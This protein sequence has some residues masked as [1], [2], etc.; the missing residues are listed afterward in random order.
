MRLGN[1]RSPETIVR[2]MSMRT[3]YN[4]GWVILLMFMVV[5][6]M[7]ACFLK[8]PGT[9]GNQLPQHISLR[10]G[11]L[12]S[13]LSPDN[14]WI[15]CMG[16]MGEQAG[17][18][19]QDIEGREVIPVALSQQAEASEG[20]AISYHS[21]AW[22]PDSQNLGFI[23]FEGL[24]PGSNYKLWLFN[25]ET[26]LASTLYQSQG[27]IDAVKW[28]PDSKSLAVVEEGRLLLVRLD[29]SRQ[30][31]IE[32]GV[33]TYP[34]SGN[35]LA[36]S[37]D[38]RWLL[39]PA[40]ATGEAREVR[41]IEIST[42]QAKVLWS[43][44]E[45]GVAF[46]PSWRSDGGRIAILRG[47]YLL[48]EPSQEEVRVILVD[49]DGSDAVVKE[50]DHVAFKL[51]TSL[52]WSPDATQ[53]ATIVRRGEATDIWLIPAEEGKPQQITDTGN[54]RTLIKWMSDGRGLVLSTGETIETVPIQR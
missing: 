13:N 4:P 23:S 31:L 9:E 14:Y 36:W 52:L 51:G 8:Q 48:S 12:E 43:N 37:P 20:E 49:P 10:T 26:R 17:I 44:S 24:P 32:E 50:C 54:I 41:V 38:G 19:T 27:L 6:G 30:M 28:S 46:I 25:V 18:W 34:L 33:V 40:L 45:E 5:L 22:A 29:G 47:R 2:F 21:W 35:A 39:Y 42:G 1:T 16:S 3:R 15:A 11:C 53:L 7:S